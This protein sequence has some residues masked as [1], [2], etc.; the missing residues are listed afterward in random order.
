MIET[1][2]AAAAA[3]AV[4]MT[5]A[6]FTRYY[7]GPVCNSQQILTYK[8]ELLTFKMSTVKSADNNMTV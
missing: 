6:R 2:A 7:V 3:A 4:V 1:A 5:G 8:K